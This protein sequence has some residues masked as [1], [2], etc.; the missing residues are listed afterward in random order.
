MN[1]GAFNAV[2]PGSELNPSNVDPE[3]L[4]DNGYAE[5]RRI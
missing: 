1:P 4:K 5:Y 2:L 3:I